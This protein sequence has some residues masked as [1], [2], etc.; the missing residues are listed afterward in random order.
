M[1][2]TKE[3]FTKKDFTE[4]LKCPVWPKIIPSKRNTDRGTCMLS[5]MIL[6]KPQMAV[7]I[8]FP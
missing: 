4:S 3:G 1:A 2:E 8:L 5:I 7:G 6:E